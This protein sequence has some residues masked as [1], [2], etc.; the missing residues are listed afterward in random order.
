MFG[1]FWGYFDKWNFSYT[2]SVDSFWATV[3]KIGLILIPTSGH[4][5]SQLRP[6]QKRGTPNFGRREFEIFISSFA[7]VSLIVLLK[8][9]L[10]SIKSA[11]LMTV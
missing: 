2:T 3:G 10:G 1:K 6:P 5:A 9:L 7:S 4:T 8:L 11:S